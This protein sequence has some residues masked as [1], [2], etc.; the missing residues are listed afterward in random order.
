MNINNHIRAEN[1]IR[2]LTKEQL[3]NYIFNYPVGKMFL[4]SIA[5]E[6]TAQDYGRR[7]RLPS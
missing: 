1:L 7:C 6:M 2:S 5:D 3:E 4:A